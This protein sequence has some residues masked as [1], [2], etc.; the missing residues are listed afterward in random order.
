[1]AFSRSSMHISLSGTHLRAK[2]RDRQGCYH[3]SAID[4]NN[5]IVNDNGV[6]KWQASGNFAASSRGIVI[7][8]SVL[9]CQSRSRRGDWC[10]AQI[11]LDE[12]IA[13]F[14]GKFIYAFER[15]IIHVDEKNVE[16]VTQYMKD[17]YD[18]HKGEVST[19]VADGGIYKVCINPNPGSWGLFGP[20]ACISIYMVW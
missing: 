10:R 3:D 14:N 11:N 7:E 20:D 16:E 9:R 18:A 12:K 8:G 17:V 1:M 19:Q 15:A 5:Y 13:N 2:C 4:I 6:L